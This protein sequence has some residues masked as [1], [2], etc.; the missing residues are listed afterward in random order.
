MVK[1]VVGVERKKRSLIRRLLS[2]FI[3]GSNS[4]FVQYLPDIIFSSEIDFQS[5][6]RGW[7]FR[8]KKNNDAD[9]VRLLF[10]VANIKQLASEDIQGDIA[11]LGVFRG[12][13]AKVLHELALERELYLLDTFS[14][15]SGNDLTENEPT[16][17]VTGDFNAGLDEVKSFVGEHKSIHY[18]PGYFPDTAAHIPEDARFAFVN[19]DVDLYEPMKAGLEFFYPR[20]SKGGMMALHDY[21]NSCWPG[22]KKAVDEFLADKPE[23]LVILPDRSGSASFRKI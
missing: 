1:R 22:V 12:N 9:L 4:Y 19:L 14:G 18:I 5:L 23:R 21:A 16:H 11:E 3:N 6:R 17:S 15:F 7:I 8:N 13:A 10:L 20:L 2:N